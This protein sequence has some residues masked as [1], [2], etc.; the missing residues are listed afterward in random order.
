MVKGWAIEIENLSKRF[1]KH[2]ALREI[3]LKVQYGEAIALLGPNGAGKTTLIKVLATLLNPSSGRISI[4]NMDI[5]R[6]RQSIRRIVG[7][8]THKTFLYSELTARENLRFYCRMYNVPNADQRIEEV[9]E[10]VGM[11]SYADER[12]GNLSR[13]MQQ[14]LSLGRCVLHNPSILLLDEPETGLDKETLSSLWQV[15]RMEGKTER[16]VIAATHDIE[17]GQKAGD[18][19]ILLDQGKVAY[20]GSTHELGLSELGHIYRA[21]T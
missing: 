3:N 5:R 18:R 11:S 16:T 21:L 12:T 4:A 7:V 10:M 8:A 1:S 19:V 13:G 2:H 6:A 17:W 14:R 15:L 9:M 20:D